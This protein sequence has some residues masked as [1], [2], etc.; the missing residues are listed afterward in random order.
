MDLTL[1][2][3]PWL[4][5]FQNHPDASFGTP[6]GS[7][8]LGVRDTQWPRKKNHIRPFIP[9]LHPPSSSS[10]SCPFLFPLL[11]LAP[12]PFNRYINVFNC[13]YGHMLKWIFISFYVHICTHVYMHINIR[14]CTT[15]CYLTPS[16]F[17]PGPHVTRISP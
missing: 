5:F 14:I 17:F 16:L 12:R 11:P 10:N 1:F 15:N 6:E 8:F 9:T 4:I 2:Q 3:S 7:L 13:F